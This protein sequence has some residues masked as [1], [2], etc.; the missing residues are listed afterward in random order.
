MAK[1]LAEHRIRIAHAPLDDGSRSLYELWRS[2]N[3][4]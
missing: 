4:G 3:P 1:P 2:L